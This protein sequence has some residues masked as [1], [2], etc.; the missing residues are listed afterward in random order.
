MISGDPLCLIYW[1]E[2]TKSESAGSF[3]CR[4]NARPVVAPRPAPRAACPR[5]SPHRIDPSAF[6]P[7]PAPRHSKS[8]YKSRS[9]SGASGGH[10][11]ENRQCY[12]IAPTDFCRRI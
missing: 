9:R 6:L 10:A 3:G 4:D 11:S 1:D 5:T 8:N 7:S 12:H 2:A